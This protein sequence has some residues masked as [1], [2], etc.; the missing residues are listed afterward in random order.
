MCFVY[1][2][3]VVGIHQLA[4]K[5]THRAE[6]IPLTAW[7]GLLMLHGTASLIFGGKKKSQSYPP[8]YPVQPKQQGPNQSTSVGPIQ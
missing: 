7:S 3:V 5:S 4:T 6:W 1:P 2:S 8:K